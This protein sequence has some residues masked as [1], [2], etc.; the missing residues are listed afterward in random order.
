MAGSEGIEDMELLPIGDVPHAEGVAAAPASAQQRSGRLA[1]AFAAL[2]L[3]AGLMA[4]AAASP[5][6]V[7]KSPE[8]TGAAQVA[9]AS[10]VSHAAG[11]VVQLWGDQEY[12]CGGQLC[13]CS[14][15][16]NP[17]SCNTGAYATTCGSCCC[18]A[19]HGHYREYAHG[20]H[21]DVTIALVVIGAII[22]T[23]IVIAVVYHCY[24]KK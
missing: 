18:N 14:W 3:G 11:K 22:I 10:A 5:G 19:Y 17:T 15:A 4:A 9:A 2:L 20:P 8:D 13:D 6:N 23:I 16:Q 21:N 12:M 1:A 7:A 24:W